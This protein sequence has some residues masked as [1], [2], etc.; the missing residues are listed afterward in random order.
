[1][2]P[3][4]AFLKKYWQTILLVLVIVF[5]GFWVKHVQA[6]FAKALTDLNN[7]HQTEINQINDA[8]AQETKEREEQIKQLQASIDKIQ[9][10]YAAAQAAAKVKQ[11][12]DA[13]Q[14]VKK[15]GNDA[16]GL[17]NLLADKLGFTV[18][19]PASP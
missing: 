5:A 8:R 17:A 6:N 16:D 18:V 2:T 4:L 14:I 10:D 12:E 9:T 3:V 19:K 11:A 1:V 15:Y 7:S 13:K